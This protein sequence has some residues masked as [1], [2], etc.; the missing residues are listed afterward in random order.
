MLAGIAERIAAE[1]R[2]V[3]EDLPS[4][5]PG[6]Q[7]ARHHKQIGPQGCEKEYGAEKPQA[8]VGEDLQPQPVPEWIQQPEFASKELEVPGHGPNLPRE[9]FSRRR[10]N[11]VIGMGP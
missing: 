6:V 9:L 10:R 7:G 5:G 3:K 1:R 2:R 11:P 4:K 8:L